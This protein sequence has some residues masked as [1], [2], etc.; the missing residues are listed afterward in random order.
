MKTKSDSIY[1]NAFPL[2]TVQCKQHIHP[3]LEI[4][5]HFRVFPYAIENPYNLKMKI[6]IVNKHKDK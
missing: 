1:A 5:M 6:N 4:S 2:L 3:N